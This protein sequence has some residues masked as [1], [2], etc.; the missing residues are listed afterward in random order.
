MG[1]K[2][3]FPIWYELTK[4][5][6]LCKLTELPVVEPGFN[7]GH[8]PKLIFLSLYSTVS[9]I[10]RGIHFEEIKRFS[11]KQTEFTRTMFSKIKLEISSLGA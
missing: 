3:I 4:V 6:K 9:Q 1:G 2:A 7:P 5:K 8:I 11:F 10:Q